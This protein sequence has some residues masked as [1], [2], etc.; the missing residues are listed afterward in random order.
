MVNIVVRQFNL[1]EVCDA[2]N[3]TAEIIKEIVEQGIL[4]PAGRRPEEWAFTRDMIVQTERAA[5]LHHDLEIDWPGIALAVSLI[6][7][8][9][10][11]RRDNRSLRS[12]L[13]KFSQ[14][15]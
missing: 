6:E 3:L 7:E 5:R 12:Q 4:D 14:K 1:E 2:T 8:L 10:Q 15:L 11:L 13:N 9:N